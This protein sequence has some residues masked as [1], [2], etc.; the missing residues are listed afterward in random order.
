LRSD[1]VVSHLLVQDD[2]RARGVAFVDRLTKRAHEV[3]AR[4]IVLC[5]STLESTR[6]LL[7]SRSRQHPRGLGNSSGVLGH[8]LMDH[9][10]VYVSGFLPGERDKL[11][12]D[13]AGGP[14][15]IMVPRFHN[16]EN[17]ADGAFLR[18]Y[19]MFGGIGRHAE[20]VRHLCDSDEVPFTLVAYGEMLPRFE[21][22]A[23]LEPGRTDAWGVPLL[24]IDCG[25][26][27][28]ERALLDHMVGALSEMVHVAGGRITSAPTFVSP[29][30][31]VHEMGT[32]RMGTSRDTSVVNPFGQCW[33]APNVYVMDGA[34]WPSSAWQNPTFT[35]MAI[36]G[37]ASFHLATQLRHGLL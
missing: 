28:N 14:K 8:Y 30:G 35:M 34:V 33:D 3:Y 7:H 27:D 5:A 18:G 12:D 2:G 6:I 13:G 32:A 10:A 17:R 22:H 16:L 20:S 36:A 19:G 25:F 37:R 1:A 26:S 11:W 4:A 9:P 15:N 24:R 29:G 21:N 23:A 31:F